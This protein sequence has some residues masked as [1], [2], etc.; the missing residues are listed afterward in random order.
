MSKE[1]ETLEQTLMVEI[2]RRKTQPQ[3]RGLTDHNKD[4][5]ACKLETYLSTLIRLQK[6]SCGKFALLPS[7][8]EPKRNNGYAALILL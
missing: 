3:N 1:F 4:A 2:I 5:T 7:S 8:I 6:K